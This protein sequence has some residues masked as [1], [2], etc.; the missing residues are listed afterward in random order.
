MSQFEYSCIIFGL[1]TNPVIFM[2]YINTTF[3]YLIDSNNIF[4]YLD[5][6]L[7]SYETLDENTYILIEGCHVIWLR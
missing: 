4:V 1:Y 7:I 6:I 5:N 3:H 2:R